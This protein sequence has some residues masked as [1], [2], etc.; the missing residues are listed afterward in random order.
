MISLI[1]ALA[2]EELIP[3]LPTPATRDMGLFL[4]PRM[5]NFQR[6]LDLVR[7]HCGPQIF[8]T[9]LGEELLFPRVAAS[10]DEGPV[11]AM[12][13]VADGVLLRCTTCTCRG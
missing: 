12:G 4:G 10:P 11:R 2:V 6:E 9:V 7:H 8:N 5:A 1:A 13:L 3:T